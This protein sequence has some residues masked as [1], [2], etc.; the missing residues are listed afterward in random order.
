[1]PVIVMAELRALRFEDDVRAVLRVLA[2]GQDGVARVHEA[3]VDVVDAG[4]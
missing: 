4:A 1:M 2:D 3:D